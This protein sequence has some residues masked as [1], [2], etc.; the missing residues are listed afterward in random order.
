MEHWQKQLARA[1]SPEDLARLALQKRPGDSFFLEAGGEVL[2]MPNPRPAEALLD[3]LYGVLVEAPHDDEA[4]QP[5]DRAELA[6]EVFTR[7]GIEKQVKRRVSVD[8]TLTS[9]GLFDRHTFDY[10]FDN[11]VSTVMRTMTLGLW[12]RVH[13]AVF[14]F[15]SVKSQKKFNTGTIIVTPEKATDELAGQVGLIRE[16]AQVVNLFDASVAAQQLAGILKLGA[17]H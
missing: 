7:L 9:A 12:E 3:E 4:D 13:S 11:G 14:S 8:L 6:E 17:Q 1:A 10:R 16:H 15:A 5:P 2:S